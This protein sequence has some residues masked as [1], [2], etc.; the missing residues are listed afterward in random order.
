ML[1]P[2]LLHLFHISL[3]PTRKWNYIPRHREEKN[4]SFYFFVTV[5]QLWKSK[6]ALKGFVIFHS[7]FLLCFMDVTQTERKQIVILAPVW[8]QDERFDPFKQL[9]K[10]E[11]R[12]FIIGDYSSLDC[13]YVRT[14]KGKGFMT[15][16]YLPLC[17]NEM[18][19]HDFIS[20]SFDSFVWQSV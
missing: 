10:K 1:S 17:C 15:N 4:R 12:G 20:S 16:I 6:H 7:R 13:R 18:T 5:I 3:L 8:G 11:T 14:E 19:N 9:F 2:A